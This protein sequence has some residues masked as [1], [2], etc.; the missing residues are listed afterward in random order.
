MEEI[1][2]L[3]TILRVFVQVSLLSVQSDVLGGAST[4]KI[5]PCKQV[6]KNI[7][8]LSPAM[9]DHYSEVTLTRIK[10]MHATGSLGQTW[11]MDGSSF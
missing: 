1:R 3:R 5:T 4:G 10:A 9:L 6:R 7:V 2:A 8:P 11:A